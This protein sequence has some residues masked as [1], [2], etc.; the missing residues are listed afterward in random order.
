MKASDTKT[1]T[2]VEKHIRTMTDAYLELGVCVIEDSWA[3]AYAENNDD[4]VGARKAHRQEYLAVTSDTFVRAYIRVL[5][6]EL[7]RPFVFADVKP[8]EVILHIP[9]RKY[10]EPLFASFLL[11]PQF[12]Y[13]KSDKM[14]VCYRSKP[15][16]V[17]V[18]FKGNDG[19][20][21]FDAFIERCRTEEDYKKALRTQ[22]A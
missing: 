5:S 6:K 10:T 19:K 14:P 13:R 12:D 11:A 20:Q 22:G 8:K 3:K 16:L 4:Y 9:R 15:S 7:K 1:F 18:F 2:K 17:Q 21:L